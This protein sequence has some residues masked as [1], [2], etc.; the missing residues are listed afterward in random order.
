MSDATV[1]LLVGSIVGVLVFALVS[2][3]LDSTPA[4]GWALVVNAVWFCGGVLFQ[5]LIFY[6]WWKR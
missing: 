5:A 2:G 4:T 6:S 1:G 3:P